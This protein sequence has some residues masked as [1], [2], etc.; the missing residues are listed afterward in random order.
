MRLHNDRLLKAVVVCD[1]FLQ[2]QMRAMGLHWVVEAQ[3][4]AVSAADM[5]PPV[6]S[7]M[8]EGGHCLCAV[9]AYLP[10]GDN[11]RGQGLERS[12][13]DRRQAKDKL[14]SVV[15]PV[16]SGDSRERGIVRASEVGA[17]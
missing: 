1:E 4:K 17:Q 11:P 15:E 8:K 14:L 5:L 12:V 10:V 3:D 2:T 7:F 6:S 16:S 9:E 13:H